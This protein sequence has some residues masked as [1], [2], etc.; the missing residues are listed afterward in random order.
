MSL[1]LTPVLL[2]ALTGRK[3][4]S[5]IFHFSL[6]FNGGIF[7]GYLMHE[8][9]ETETIPG[10]L[11]HTRVRA[12]G[13]KSA[14]ISSHTRTGDGPQLFSSSRA[15]DGRRTAG[16]SHLTRVRCMG[17]AGGG[18][19]STPR[20]HS[21]SAS[22]F[23]RGCLASHVTPRPH[24]CPHTPRCALTR[25][26]TP[27]HTHTCPHTPRCALT[28]PHVPS[29]LT[30]CPYTP[31]YALT[32]TDTPSHTRALP[33]PP[34]HAPSHSRTRSPALLGTLPSHT[35][36]LPSHTRLTH[37]PHTPP[38]PPPYTLAPSRAPSPQR[39]A[40]KRRAARGAGRAHGHT[41]AHTHSHSLTLTHV[42]THTTLPRHLP[43]GQPRPRLKRVG[44]DWGFVQCL[45]RPSPAVCP[46][47]FPNVK[48]RTAH[49]RNKK[50]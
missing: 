37:T 7:L 39:P 25:N 8:L 23:V 13:E 12:Q 10:Y 15:G 48:T 34:L 43:G 36:T 26:P 20:P 42:H 33:V 3:G 11:P 22:R 47:G 38:P 35:H 5:R 1:P 41:Q 4:N 30:P 29:H 16:C 18:S 19:P 6:H 9:T 24:T 17:I 45:L 31:T 50:K 21:A 14:G 28:H 46:L 32:L 49:W 27:S 2:S 40:T 44:N